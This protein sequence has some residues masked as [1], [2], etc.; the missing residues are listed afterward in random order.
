VSMHRGDLEP[1]LARVLQ[2]G[3]Y[4]SIGLVAAGV[5]LLIASGGSPLAGGPPFDAGGLVADVTA[6]RPAGL[7]WLGILG[8]IATPGVRVLGALVG[9]A[10]RGEG[11]MAALAGAILVVV[12]AGVVAGLVTG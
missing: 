5:V 3:S 6:G 7:L 4:L 10:R 11:A 2:A 1:G 9:F 12:A 8:I